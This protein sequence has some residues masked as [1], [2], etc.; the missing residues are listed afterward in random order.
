MLYKYLKKL[1][2][3]VEEFIWLRLY[4]R[5]MAYQQSLKADHSK[6]VLFVCHTA[7]HL[8]CAILI[9]RS[10]SLRAD[11]LLYPGLKRAEEIKAILDEK[12]IF[13]SVTIHTAYDG[14]NERYVKAYRRGMNKWKKKQRLME[15]EHDFSMLK[16]H[17]V[18]IFNDCSSL[19]YYLQVCSIPYRIIEDGLN[20][21]FSFWWDK[22][23]KSELENARYY[24]GETKPMVWGCSPLA[25]EIDLNS[26]ENSAPSG[27]WKPE[28]I[29]RSREA[30]YQ[31]LSREEKTFMLR[32]FNAQE[33]AK[34]LDS[35]KGLKRVLLL[36][37]VLWEDKYLPSEEA[38]LK[39][40]EELL[41]KYAAGADAV[42]IKPHPRSRKDF[43]RAKGRLSEAYVVRDCAVP[44]EMLRFTD[45]KFWRI[46]AVNSTAAGG[47]V[48]AEEVISTGGELMG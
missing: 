4:R 11:L 9:S 6:P 33:F 45:Q 30:L 48:N 23:M 25:R 5:R 16:S 15:S 17:C 46:I 40:L 3:A 37:A 22:Y 20:F 27:Y 26:I 12:G 13:N 31:D 1:K 34:E 2:Q 14:D 36:S 28:F 41:E 7:Y 39:Y 19:G 44:I 32:L 18:Y 35:V 29:E 42:I 24:Y 38:E 43:T 21:R 8:L 47:I 10:E